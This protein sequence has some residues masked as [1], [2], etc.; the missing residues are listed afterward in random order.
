MPIVVSS[1]FAYDY[2]NFEMFVCAQDDNDCYRLLVDPHD[3]IISQLL[4]VIKLPTNM[5]NS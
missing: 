5:E 1:I 4:A 2:P 3:V